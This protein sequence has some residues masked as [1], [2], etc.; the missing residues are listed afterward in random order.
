[1]KGYFRKIYRQFRVRDI[2]FCDGRKVIS[3]IKKEYNYITK[4]FIG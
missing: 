1:M 4:D 3:W 2:S